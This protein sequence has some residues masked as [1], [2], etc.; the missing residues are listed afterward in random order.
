M[1]LNVLIYRKVN[2]N[3]I[4]IE[5]D[6]LI[7]TDSTEDVLLHFGT[8]GMKW[9]VRKTASNV[10]KIYLNS[11]THP[12]LSAYAKTKTEKQYRRDKKNYKAAK[13][14]LKAEHT[15]KE[16]RNAAL[17]KL[18]ENFKNNNNMLAL[19]DRQ[20]R[21]LD[22]S[23]AAKTQYKFEKA[24][25]TTKNEKKNAKAKYKKAIKSLDY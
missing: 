9:G 10:G 21:N 4:L 14:K 25:A 13:K 8:K 23:I 5:D 7:H 3:M 6:K 20:A 16:S 12:I 11:Y 2:K 1:L 19:I 24:R 18:K 22:N 17:K 15:N